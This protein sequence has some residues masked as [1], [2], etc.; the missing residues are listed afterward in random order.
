MTSYK[1]QNSIANAETILGYAI[2][3]ALIGGGVG[4]LAKSFVKRGVQP[5]D[6]PVHHEPPRQADRARAPARSSASS[7]A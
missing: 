5:S 2:G 3:V 7:S 6:A 1:L 4:F